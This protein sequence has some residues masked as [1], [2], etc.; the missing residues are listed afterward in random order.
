MSWVRDVLI[1]DPTATR[2]VPP[3][4]FTAALT[5]ASA[6]AMAFLAVFA[7]AVHLATGELATRWEA[8]LAGTATVRIPSREDGGTAVDAVLTAL[9]QTPGIAEARVITAEEQ[10]VLLA[11]WFGEGLPLDRLRFPTLIA[12]T[13]AGDGP[14]VTGLTE[15]LG[16]EAPGAIYDNHSRW[17]VPLANAAFRLRQL[18]VFALLLI[19]GVT[20]VTIALAASAALSANGQVIDVLR[21][22][23]ARDRWI[24]AAFTRRFTLRAFAGA[25]GGTI[26]AM[27]AVALVPGG[28]ETGVLS[29]LGFDGTEWLWPLLV[30]FIAA[31]LAFAATRVA[32]ARRLKEDG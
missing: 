15:R 13:E 17:R 8:E 28:V 12:V 9:S 10:T 6:A 30:P 14:D 11:P 7:I 4:G 26:V 29:G 31:G 22:V 25:L 2:I 5:I 16:A 18:G 3:S 19:A 24:A 1:G 21:I 32:A 20:A 27:V 23:G